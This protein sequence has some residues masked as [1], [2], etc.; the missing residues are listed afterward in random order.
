MKGRRP[1]KVPAGLRDRLDCTA[2]VPSWLDELNATLPDSAN[3]FRLSA[4]HDLPESRLFLLA[5]PG[6]C[7]DDSFGNQVE[8]TH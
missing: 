6:L 1:T 5:S 4:L 8:L 2:A 7:G 3:F